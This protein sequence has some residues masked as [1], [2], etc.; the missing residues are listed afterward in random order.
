MQDFCIYEAFR[1]YHGKVALLDEHKLRWENS[2]KKIEWT[3]S[4][5]DL[6]EQ[7]QEALCHP[8]V[9]GGF[10]DVKIR[11]EA[12]AGGFLHSDFEFIPRYEG[13]FLH[14]LWKIKK[15]RGARENPNIKSTKTQFQSYWRKRAKK[16]GYDEIL[17]IDEGGQVREGG[18]SNVFFEKKG[19]LITPS[20]GMLPGI[21]RQL[22]LK[23]AAHLNIPTE[24]RF[25]HESELREMDG[26]F[27]TNSIKGIIPVGNVTD[28]MKDLADFCSSF[29]NQR[30]A[31]VSETKFMGIVNITP[32]SFSDGGEFFWMHDKNK[33]HHLL[34]TVQFMI[35][36]GADVIDVGG[37]STGPGSSCVS[38]DE[39]LLRVIPSIQMIHRHFPEI[40]I[41]VDTW[42]SE[43]AKEALKV[44]A[45]M[46]NDVTGGRGDPKIFEVAAAHDAHMIIMYSKDNTPRTS[47]DLVEYEDVMAS[48]KDF[49]SVQ[50]AKA[51]K[52]GVRKIIID[53][54]MGAFISAIPRYSYEVMDRV[55]ELKTFGL[56]ILLGVSKKSCLGEDSFG[57]T[58]ASTLWL[59]GRVDYLRVHDVLENATVSA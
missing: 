36:S 22:V 38:L 39:E 31:Q 17:M 6:V 19:V 12:G 10:C 47:T 23:A 30:I 46:I 56:P 8:R 1:T 33:L 59:R 20:H 9:K 55:E 58:L 25:V 18:I 7:A 54:G 28:M 11:V 13:S 41:S 29:I 16:E 32:D 45:S 34:E 42:K 44:G 2:L 4:F 24:V 50:I 53:P 3:G 37:E 15:V 40:M 52:L 57:G 21:A 51:R 14:P 43:V 48:I 26:M 27:M 5:P 35:E 49:L